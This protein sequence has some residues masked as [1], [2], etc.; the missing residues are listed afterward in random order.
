MIRS[1][2]AEE[3]QAPSATEQMSTSRTLTMMQQSSQVVHV[4]PAR[5]AAALVRRG[6]VRRTVV[7]PKP[8]EGVAV[9]LTVLGKSWRPR[10][11]RSEAPAPT[12]EPQQPT[13]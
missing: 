4:I 12:P 9:N 8:E 7:S 1:V 2:H 11:V 13:E 10:T 3:T 6:L 5:T